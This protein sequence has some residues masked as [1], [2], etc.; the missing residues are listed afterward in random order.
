MARLVLG[1]AIAGTWS[2][3]LAVASHLVP[4]DKLGRA[5]SVVNIGVAGATVAA[6]PLGALISSFAGWRAVFWAVSV[7]TAARHRR[8][9]S[10]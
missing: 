10:S 4:A 2:M 6:V 9:S 5:M 3:A 8:C 1:V 7:A